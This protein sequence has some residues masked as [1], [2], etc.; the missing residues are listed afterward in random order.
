MYFLPGWVRNV[1]YKDKTLEVRG[2]VNRSKQHFSMLVRH[3][4]A[5]KLNP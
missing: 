5:I 1:G 4:S 2:W 3:P